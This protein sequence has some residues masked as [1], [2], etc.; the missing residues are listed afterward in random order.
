MVRARAIN[1]A[2]FPVLLV[3]VLIVSP[4]LAAIARGDPSVSDNGNGTKTAVWDFANPG[5][6]TI[7]N[8]ALAPNEARLRSVPGG[9]LQTSSADFVANGTADS[10]TNVTNDSVRLSG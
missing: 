7:S 10:A 1:P 4:C 8:M 9:W 2:I 5:N 6:Y 3:T